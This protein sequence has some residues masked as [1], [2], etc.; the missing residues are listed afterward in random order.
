MIFRHLIACFFLCLI[1][2]GMSYGQNVIYDEEAGLLQPSDLLQQEIEEQG[3]QAYIQ[4]V[5]NGNH[6]TVEQHLSEEQASNLIKVLQEGNRHHAYIYQEGVENQLA[7]IQSGHENHYCLINQGEEN[8]IVVIQDGS[9]NLVVQELINT[10]G[11]NVELIQEGNGNE[12]IQILEGVEARD[13]KV[14]Q[15]G[16]NLRVI[17]RQSAY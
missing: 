14:Y 16:D 10:R 17:I 6:L 5:G 7:L 13:Y 4:Q 3:N 2:L 12:I 9:D 15:R 11:V 8:L 1:S